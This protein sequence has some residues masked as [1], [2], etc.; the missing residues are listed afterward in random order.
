MKKLITLIIILIAIGLASCQKENIEPNTII[1][2]I[3]IT[4]TLFVTDTI[5]LTDTVY[6][7]NNQSSSYFIQVQCVLG[8]GMLGPKIYV[9]GTLFYATQMTAFSGD[10]IQIVFDGEYGNNWA[11]GKVWVNNELVVNHFGQGGIIYEE[12]ME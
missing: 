8:C 10:H 2:T 11:E 7:E 5:T 3:T 6:I 12:I 9:N 4:D 1:D